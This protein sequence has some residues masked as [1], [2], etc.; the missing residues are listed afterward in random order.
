MKIFS[1]KNL[2]FFFFVT[3]ATLVCL[4]VFAQS[5]ETGLD[6]RVELE[7]QQFDESQKLEEAVSSL[8]QTSAEESIEKQANTLSPKDLDL[9]SQVKTDESLEKQAATIL[10]EDLPEV[11]ASQPVEAKE[12]QQPITDSAALQPLPKKTDNFERESSFESD[13]PLLAQTDIELGRLT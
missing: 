7:L 12:W 1:V 6:E 3:G 11:V 10:E 13:V 9:L 2:A 8:P 4:P 5:E